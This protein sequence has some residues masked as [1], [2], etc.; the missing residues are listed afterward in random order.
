MKKSR[1]K[2]SATRTIEISKALPKTFFI[3]ATWT[4]FFSR[5]KIKDAKPTT[6][7]FSSTIVNLPSSLVSRRAT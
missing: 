3:W 7:S 1:F 6:I 5:V 2:L 4:V